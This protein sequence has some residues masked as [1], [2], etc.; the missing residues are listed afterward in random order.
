[1]ERQVLQGITQRRLGKKR[2]KRDMTSESSE[3]Q[4]WLSYSME[5]HEEL[6]CAHVTYLDN[7]SFK[8]VNQKAKA[9]RRTCLQGHHTATTDW[10]SA[11]ANET[12]KPMSFNQLQICLQ[13]KQ[14]LIV[15]TECLIFTIQQKISK[16]GQGDSR[17]N[18]EENAENH[19]NFHRNLLNI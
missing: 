4:P 15:I 9:L 19:H 8:F 12:N 13:N 11:Q 17:D 3:Q 2:D 5:K 7:S 16:C 10:L 18:T 14:Y 6:C 1:M